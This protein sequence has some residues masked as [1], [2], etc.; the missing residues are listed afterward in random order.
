MIELNLLKSFHQEVKKIKAEAEET[1]KQAK[2]TTQ[3]PAAV[4]ALKIRYDTAQLDLELSN[5]L[6]QPQEAIQTPSHNELQI[7]LT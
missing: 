3:F 7:E 1:Y 5:P 2:S 4:E 6:T